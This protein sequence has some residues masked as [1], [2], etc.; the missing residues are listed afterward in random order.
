MGDERTRPV[1]FHPEADKNG[2]GVA[3]HD[4][5]LV[6]SPGRPARGGYFSLTR[7]ART[8]E[9]QACGSTT[10]VGTA[11]STAKIRGHCWKHCTSQ[12]QA[13]MHRGGR[14]DLVH[15]GTEACC[16]HNYAKKGFFWRFWVE[17]KS[18]PSLDTILS[19]SKIT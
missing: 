2:A 17:K 7:G 15:R 8:T 4:R 13:E 9:G 3:V 18:F 12:M 11:K 10:L 19:S 16:L 5:G 6:C 14:G 1:V